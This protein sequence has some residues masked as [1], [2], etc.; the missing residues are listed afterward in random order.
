MLFGCT[1]DICY[2]RVFGCHAW[3]HVPKDQ[4]TKW[5]PN[6]VPMIFVGYEPGSKAYRLWDPTTCSIK[7]S[8]AVR[9]DKTQLLCKSMPKPPVQPEPVT[10]SAE[11]PPTYVS[12]DY[13]NE[14]PPIPWSAEEIPLLP[15]SS[16]TLSP[17]LLRHSTP[18]PPSSTV[19]QPPTDVPQSSLG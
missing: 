7:V 3:A 9:F 10:L 11:I 8:T 19:I 17:S 18:E 4:R 5:K 14:D 6:S 13:W 15:S 12:V 16:P 2:L 1:P